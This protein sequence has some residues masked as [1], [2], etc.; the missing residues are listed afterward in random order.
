VTVG[1]PDEVR[2]RAIE[3]IQEHLREEQDLE[4]G[5]LGAEFLLDKVLEEVAP[6]VY[7]RAIADAQSWL[8]AKL[9][10]LD[11]DLFRAEPR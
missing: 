6:A 4:I 10:D 11:S 1:L 2:R 9:L 8:Q 7:N 3:A 5:N